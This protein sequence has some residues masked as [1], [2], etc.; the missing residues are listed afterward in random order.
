FSIW[1]IILIVIGSITLFFDVVDIVRWLRGE[2]DVHVI[3]LDQPLIF[4]EEV[5]V[6]APAAAVWSTLG[7]Y[8]SYPD[9]NP[10]V[11]SVTGETNKLGGNIMVKVTPLPFK[12][13]AEIDLLEEN[14][15]V[16]WTDQF[17]LKML[18]AR[19]VSTIIDK[20]DGTSTYVFE[21]TFAGPAVPLLAGNLRKQLPPIYKKLVEAVK[22][23]AEANY[24]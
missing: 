6:N 7:D 9:W 19:P 3:G 17:P 2:R 5:A 21:E 4:R 12:L 14:K 24:S 16:G 1:V 22:E 20:N 23:R 10:L 8:S 18:T 11:Q 15:A 13:S